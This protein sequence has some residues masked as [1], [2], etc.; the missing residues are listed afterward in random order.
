MKLHPVEAWGELGDTQQVFRACGTLERVVTSTV[1]V[2]NSKTNEI[3]VQLIDEEYTLL[4]E[5]S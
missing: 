2:N 3:K 1:A 5:V 4:S